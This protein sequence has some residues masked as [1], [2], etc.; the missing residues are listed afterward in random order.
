[1]KRDSDFESKLFE[2]GVI[3]YII[4]SFYIAYY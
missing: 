4:T 3:L 1:M 2:K